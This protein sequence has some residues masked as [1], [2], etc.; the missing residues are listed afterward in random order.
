MAMLL[1]HLLL[2]NLLVFSL[3]QEP[4]LLDSGDG[5]D[6]Y[7]PSLDD[8]DVVDAD[9]K[10]DAR[11]ASPESDFEDDKYIYYQPKDTNDLQN[12]ELKKVIKGYGVDGWLVL[13]PMFFL[14][15]F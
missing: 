6:G 15:K 14:L 5:Y 7:A 12:K 2:L 8:N 1:S 10:N 11:I 4:L 9:L 3:G 13:S